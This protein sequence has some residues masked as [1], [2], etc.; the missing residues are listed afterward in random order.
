[1]LL[2]KIDAEK[3]EQGILRYDFDC[4]PLNRFMNH[5]NEKPVWK[6][7]LADHESS[8]YKLF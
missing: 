1:M 6:K 5:Y 2:N 8:L 4:M 3:K 7:L